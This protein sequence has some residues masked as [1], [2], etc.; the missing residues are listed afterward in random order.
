MAEMVKNERS[1]EFLLPVEAASCKMWEI[2]RRRQHVSA[3]E[4]MCLEMKE[5]GLHVRQMGKVR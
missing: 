1:C 3:L 2:W 4:G 5:Q